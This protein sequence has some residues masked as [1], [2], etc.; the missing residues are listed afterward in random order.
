MSWIDEKAHT[1]LARIREAREKQVRKGAALVQWIVESAQLE[2]K[3]RIAKAEVV[4]STA[5]STAEML[6]NPL[7]W[8][9]IPRVISAAQQSIALIDSQVVFPPAELFMAQGGVVGGP[10]DGPVDTVPAMISTG[11]AVIDRGRTR[12]LLEMADV[13]TEG[14]GQG[15][16]VNVYLN[17]P[18]GKMDEETMDM[19]ADGL[20]RRISAAVRR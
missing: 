8:P 13:I 9:F 3:K 4:I 5:R 2:A 7:M 19:I 17:N 11:E 14:G 10:V 20:G 6:G 15:M 16:T 12:Q 18:V 1:E